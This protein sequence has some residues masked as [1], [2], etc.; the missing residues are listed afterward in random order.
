[1]HVK[2]VILTFR[3][4]AFKPIKKVL[5]YIKEISSFPDNSVVNAGMVGTSIIMN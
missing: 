1:M 5:N 2:F 3:F 4:H